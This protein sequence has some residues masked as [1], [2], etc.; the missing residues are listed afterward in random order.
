[1]GWALAR[2]LQHARG[3][4]LRLLESPPVVLDDAQLD[5]FETLLAAARGVGLT[6]DLPWPKH[7][8]LHY[9]VNY[10]KL[11]LHGSNRHGIS[12]FEPRDQG[13]Y[14]GKPVRAVFATDDEIWPIYFA[15]VNRRRIRSLTNGVV[16]IH[17]DGS[18][19]SRYH[20]AISADPRDPC[21]WTAGAVYAFPRATFVQQQQPREWLSAE[22]VDAAVELPVE[23]HDFPFLPE[24]MGYRFD[25]PP[26]RVIVRQVLRGWRTTLAR[27]R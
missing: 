15:I 27:S 22:P 1:V 25:E 19:R 24:V 12:R 14:E 17:A 2:R 7:E 8:L 5:A 13:D 11:L 20:F 6:Y 9:L 3:N 10:R 21:S 16:H 4:P 26:G 18:R 23:P